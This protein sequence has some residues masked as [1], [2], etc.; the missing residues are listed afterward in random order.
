MRTKFGF[1]AVDAGHLHHFLSGLIAHP[2]LGLDPRYERP[3]RQALFHPAQI[4]ADLETP[5]LTAILVWNDW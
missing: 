3:V 5:L 4:A 2:E 1:A